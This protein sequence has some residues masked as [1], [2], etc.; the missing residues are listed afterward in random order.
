MAEPT[1]PHLWSTA[2]NET[3][4]RM[5]RS[6]QA[7]LLS[8]PYGT[9]IALAIPTSRSRDLQDPAQMSLLVKTLPFQ[10]TI[11]V[12]F[13]FMTCFIILICI[14][15]PFTFNASKN[16]EDKHESRKFSA[17]KASLYSL[18]ATGVGTAVATLLYVLAYK[19]KSHLSSTKA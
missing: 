19:N 13:V 9:S 14:Q 10:C 12:V 4:T 15:P 5:H 7:D 17:T 11:A 18:G 2:L 1:I 3:H 6:P 8:D 16:T